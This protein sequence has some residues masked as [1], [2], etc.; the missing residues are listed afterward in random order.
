VRG[1]RW[2]PMHLR[3]LRRASRAALAAAFTLAWTAGARA[4]TTDDHAA[5]TAIVQTFEQDAAHASIASTPIAN[6]K[7]ALE[8]ATRLRAVGDEAHAK[9][10]DGLAREWA[11]MVRDLARAVDAEGAAS[12]ARRKAEDAKARVERSRALVEEGIARIGRMRA[13]LED[14]SGTAPERKAADGHSGDRA[15]GKKA[16][17]KERPAKPTATGAT[18]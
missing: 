14:A 5:A 10:A 4:Q 16:G 17:G 1:H 3:R 7:D 18:P 9:A 2:D 11:D 12:D 13:E 8:R 15:T 6:A